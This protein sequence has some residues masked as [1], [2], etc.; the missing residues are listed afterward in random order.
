[1]KLK[2][3]LWITMM[4]LMLI[5]GN[6]ALQNTKPCF[7][8][9]VY[10]ADKGLKKGHDKAKK[11]KGGKKQKKDKKSKKDRD[12]A[13]R[14]PSVPALPIATGVLI[15]LGAVGAGMYTIKRRKK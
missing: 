12:D 11:G 13:D 5:V 4:G 8:D 1:M 14:G 2:V 7:T 3:L 6:T 15:G 9:H 10:A